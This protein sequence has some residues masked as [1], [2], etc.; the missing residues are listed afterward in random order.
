M[1][2]NTKR[3]FFILKVGRPFVPRGSITIVDKEVFTDRNGEPRM[4]VYYETNKIQGV[5][6]PN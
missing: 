1:A 6:L 2:K 5:E 4:K 3:K